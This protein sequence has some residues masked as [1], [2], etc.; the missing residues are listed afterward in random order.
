MTNDEVKM[1]CKAQGELRSVYLR[2][3]KESWTATRLHKEMH[4]TLCKHTDNVKDLA[5]SAYWS[6]SA[7]GDG[8]ITAV[9]QTHVELESDRVY[10]WPNGE[11]FTRGY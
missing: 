6:I 10:R 11:F 1:V 9:Y 2:C 7:Y 3:V 4:E 8:L 5:D